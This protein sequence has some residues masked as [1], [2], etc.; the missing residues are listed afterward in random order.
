MILRFRIDRSGQTVKEQSDQGLHCLPFCLYFWT[1]YCTVKP[2]YA[3]FRI[4]TATFRVSKFQDIYGT[5]TVDA[6]RRSNTILN[7]TAPSRPNTAQMR[8]AES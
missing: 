8:S 6:D 7:N 2:H 3:K 4:I 1:H 5:A